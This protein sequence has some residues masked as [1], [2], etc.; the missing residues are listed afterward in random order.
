MPNVIPAPGRR[1]PPP[2]PGRGG[3]AAPYFGG[4]RPAAPHHRERTHPQPGLLW[5][6]RYRQNHGGQHHRQAHQ[7]APPPAQRHHGLHLGYQ[8]H[9]QGHRHH[10]GPRWGAALSGRDSVLQQ[11]AAA[12][13]AGV[14]G[15]RQ[16][17][18][19]RLH[20]GEPLFL[21]V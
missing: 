4:E 7:P 3:G 8:G 15:E 1:D 11:E 21:R 14:Y 19:D 17:H 13:F 12:V 2:E 6:L 5:P 10:A 16:D 9:H 18:P 20:H